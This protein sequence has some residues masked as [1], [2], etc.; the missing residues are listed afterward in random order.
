MMAANQNA[1]ETTVYEHSEQLI[2]ESVIDAALAGTKNAPYWTDSPDKPDTHESLTTDT[3]TDLLVVGGGYTGLWTALRAKER[4]PER[5]V[6]LVEGHECGWAASG[7]NGGFVST[8]LTHGRANGERHVPDEVDRLDELGLE[9][10]KAIQDTLEKYNIDC[11]FEWNGT[12]TVAIE[13][14]H[15]EELRTEHRAHPEGTTFFDQS[16]IQA[17]IASPLYRAG[18]WHHNESALVDPARLVWGLKEACIQK[19]IRIYENTPIS[20]VQKVGSGSS[21]RVVATVGRLEEIPTASK[22]AARSSEHPPVVTAKNVALSTN[23]FQSLIPGTKLFTVPVYDYALMTE[24]L[25]EEQAEAI[26]WKG[27]Q[28]LDDPD[29]RFHYYRVTPDRET[30]RPRILFGG[31]DAVYTYGR[32]VSTEYNHR[33]ETY[34][35]LAAHFLATFPQLEGIRFTHQWGGA[36]DTCSRFF[37]FFDKGHGG[38]SARAAGFTGLG[39]GAARFAADVLLDLLSG[40][41]TELT[42]LKMVKKRPLPFPPEP[43]AWAGIEFTK[44]E[45]VRAERRGGKKGLWL[46]ATEALG[47]GFDS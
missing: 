40:E 28:G 6:V 10:L 43:L 1:P 23:V 41:E 22:A 27:R 32:K 35:R 36:I 24:P 31:Y 34:R 21:A 16:E 46:K 11:D 44:R 20:K 3:T 37:S 17:E 7:R 13:D 42:R 26:R 18:L 4:E 30:G 19:G 9:N 12:M 15:V 25:T 29:T 33:D 45:M 2:P 38:L 5:D 39:V 14:R 8:S 47:M